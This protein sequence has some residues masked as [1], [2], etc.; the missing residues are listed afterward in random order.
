M[1]RMAADTL[2][3]I[4]NLPSESDSNADT[5]RDEGDPNLLEFRFQV[6]LF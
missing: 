5:R 3:S 1:F 2:Q 6:S 4:E